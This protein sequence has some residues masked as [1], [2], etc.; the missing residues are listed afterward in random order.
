ME[1]E[2][3]ARANGNLPARPPATADGWPASRFRYD[4]VKVKVRLGEQLEHYYILSRFLVSRMLTVTRIPQYK[5]SMICAGIAAA[6]SSQSLLGVC[7]VGSK[8]CAGAEET[9]NR[10]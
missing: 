3:V 6:C 4:Y 10:Q 5:V 9:A 7:P 1:I 2:T 8:N